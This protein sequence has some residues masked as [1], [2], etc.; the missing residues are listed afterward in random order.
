MPSFAMLLTKLS[1]TLPRQ[2]FPL[3]VI[4]KVQIG[5]NLVLTAKWKSA[6]ME[7]NSQQAGRQPRLCPAQAMAYIRR[8]KSLSAVYLCWCSK[9]TCSDRYQQRAVRE[10]CKNWMRLLILLHFFKAKDGTWENLDLYFK[11][12]Y[13]SEVSRKPKQNLD[14]EVN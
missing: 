7:G 10:L 3:Y 5:H 11:C 6:A 8:E 1:I 12:S 2:F 4:W 14:L 9:G 13:L